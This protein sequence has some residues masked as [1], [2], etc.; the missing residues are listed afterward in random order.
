MKYKSFFI[1]LIISQQLIAQDRTVHNQTGISFITGQMIDP[2]TNTYV[3][4][5]SLSYLT[6]Y[7]FL[8]SK[9]A[10]EYIR[11]RSELTI[12]KVSNE[13]NGEY[14]SFGFLAVRYL[15]PPTTGWRPYV[16]AGVGLSYA[17]YKIDG[18]SYNVNFNPKIGFGTDYTNAQG[19]TYFSSF[20]LSHFSNGNLGKENNGI[21][22]LNISVGRYF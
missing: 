1:A 22:T 5:V 2:N 20:R 10:P 13:I 11:L 7:N 6:P 21:N 12:A 8:I 3:N 9:T 18:Q 14:V 4:G 15:N 19:D 16:E 17:S